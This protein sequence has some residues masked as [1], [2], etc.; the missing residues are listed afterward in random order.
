MSLVVAD[1]PGL[2]EGAAAGK[3]FGNLFL[4]HIHRTKTLLH[5]ISVEREDPVAAYETIRAEL[6]ASHYALSDKPELVVLTKSDLVGEAVLAEKVAALSYHLNTEIL[7]VSVGDK[8]ALKTLREALLG[9][10]SLS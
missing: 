9:A 7:T 8:N 2:I 4:R 5:C 3:G 10:A 1:I 6:L